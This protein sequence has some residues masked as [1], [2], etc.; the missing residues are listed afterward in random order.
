MIARKF[1]PGT[2]W[3][4]L[5]IY[6]GSKTADVILLESLKP[7]IEQLQR[8]DP[9]P[10]LR[11]RFKLTDLN[12]YN[13]ILEKINRALKD[14]IDSREIANVV[15]D[16]YNREI[17]RYGKNT[18]KN[19]EELFHKSSELI[20]NFLDYDDDEKIIISMF[21]IDQ[22]LSKINR[23]ETEKLDWIKNYNNS[24]KHE[25][26]A[27]KNLNSQLDKK[28]RDLKPKY[29]SCI[30]CNEFEEMRKLIVSNILESNSTLETIKQYSI[31]LQ[32]F[33]QSIFHMYINR[34][35]ISEQRLFEMVVYDYL[36]RYYKS[37]IFMINK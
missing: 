1:I 27:D 37:K 4:Y 23:S 34:I 22:L 9:K 33:F 29:L 31:S 10:H 3:L 36:T 11:I 8:N 5:K 6:T 30:N 20:L 32:D 18:I 26:K 7:L 16:T 28:Y 35:F 12:N 25:F 19:A 14:F 13:E 15:F 2:E 21:Y 24:F 17:E